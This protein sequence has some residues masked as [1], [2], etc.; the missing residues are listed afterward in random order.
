MKS[1][2]LL[3]AV[4]SSALALVAARP[5]PVHVDRLVSR[6]YY[7]EEARSRGN[8]G[9]DRFGS[10]KN[11]KNFEISFYHVNDVH[12]HLDEFR[13]S[14]S[15]CT[16]PSR[17]CVGGYPRI[18]NSLFLNAGDEFQGTLFYSIYKG[19]A[20]SSILNQLGFDAMTL[21]N[22]EFD[23]GDDTLATFLSNL[24]FPVISAN[25]HSTNRK[26]QRN[27]A[28][29]KVFSAGKYRG[30]DLAI[31]AV[32][33]ETTKSI[34]NPGEGTTFE[35]P[36][37]ARHHRNVKRFVALTHIG[38]SQDIALAQESTDI[39]LI[40][41]D[42]TT[43]G[44]QGPYPTIVKNKKGEEVFVV[45]SYRWG[46]YLSYIDLEF[47]SRGRV[48]EDAKLKAEVQNWAKG[49]EPF[50]KQV[51]GHSTL[52]LD[53]ATC[54]LGECTLGDLTGDV[55]AGMS[56]SNTTSPFTGNT[57]APANGEIFAG[58]IMNAGGIRSAIDAG[59]ITMRQVLETF[60]FGNALVELKFS[61]SD[62]WNV[63]ESIVS[64][65]SVFNPGT[66]VTSFVQVSSSIRFTYD[67]S[68]PVGSRLV[69]LTVANARQST[70]T[71][72]KTW[73]LAGIQPSEFVTLDTLDQAFVNYLKGLGGLQG[74]ADGLAN[75]SIE[76]D[77]RIATVT[78]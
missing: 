27:I 77:G 56:P 63:F 3:S 68:G 51:V 70:R 53:Q 62:L 55:I 74:T 35:D 8:S 72:A 54:Q 18:K 67:A 64:K 76:L 61:S 32:T 19:E 44:A 47:D 7:E 48:A 10:L 28:P 65:S 26:L 71:R 75:L 4:L 34:S 25:V 2:L 42:N 11:K 45:T 36:V 33:T 57:T 20:T 46:E 9:K 12:A 40:I 39:S 60:P 59:D 17:G 5:E 13:P 73:V 16:D 41:A 43:A 14:G 30:F 22:H 6:S 1:T 38:Y 78:P 58:G 21:G 49:F 29:Y 15:S 37:A 66:A 23:D 69:S 31:V 50:T 52:L 24:T